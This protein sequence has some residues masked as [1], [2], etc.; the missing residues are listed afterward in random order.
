M[1]S[2]VLHLLNYM[3]WILHLDLHLASRQQKHPVTEVTLFDDFIVPRSMARALV[4]S[5]YR[6][7]VHGTSTE[8]N[9]KITCCPIF[10]KRGH[11]LI[12]AWYKSCVTSFL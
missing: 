2:S 3:V 12:W 1:L 8:A 9:R 10:A 7:A 6:P 4:R 5:F 11:R